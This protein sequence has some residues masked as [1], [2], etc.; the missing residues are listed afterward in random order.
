MHRT[1]DEIEFTIFDT[2]T[3]GLDP[4][5][6]DRIVE[7]A[8][9]RLKA[10]RII[11]EFSTLVNPGRA[12]SAAAFAVNHITPEMLEN[13][14]LPGDVLP[15]F[16]DFIAGS[17]L[18]SYNLVFD[19]GFLNAELARLDRPLPAQT[20]LVDVLGMARKLLPK[21]SSHSLCNVA[22]SLDI[23]TAQEH[24]ALA[25][26]VLTR[27]VFR[28]LVAA[29]ADKGIREFGQFLSLFSLRSNLVSDIIAQKSAKIQEAIDAGLEIT[30]KYFSRSSADVS[31]RTV[32]P[33][34]I[35]EVVP[36][37]Y[38]VGFC[39]L[40]HQ[41]RTFRIDHIMDIRTA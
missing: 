16:L 15:G 26:V 40:K 6:G 22:Q 41:E 21:L 37:A 39:K 31:E 23:R 3:T 33:K 4:G 18:C 32:I 11:A 17:C 2:E 27:E 38:L 19:L 14:P 29:L 36:F 7:I 34:E 35:K 28:I 8:A 20:A 1:I 9:Q 5:G 24:R 25:D 12:P 30:I 10:D 13:A